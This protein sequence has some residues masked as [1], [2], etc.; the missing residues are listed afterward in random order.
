LE[1]LLWNDFAGGTAGR[2]AGCQII[3]QAG[4]EESSRKEKLTKG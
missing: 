3:Y 2:L 1:K 4:R